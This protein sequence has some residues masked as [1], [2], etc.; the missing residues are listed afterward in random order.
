MSKRIPVVIPEPPS[1]D[2]EELQ[3]PACVNNP[4][5]KKIYHD[6]DM[7]FLLVPAPA[8]KIWAYH[9]RCE[10]TNRRTFPSLT[11]IK[12]KLNMNEG[13]VIKWRGWL[14]TNGWLKLLEPAQR[15]SDGKMSVPVFRVTRPDH[16]QPT[17]W[18]FP[19]GFSM[20]YCERESVFQ[21]PP[22]AFK[23][24]LFRLR[25]ERAE[26]HQSCM[27]QKELASKLGMHQKTVIT[28][29][30]YLK[31]NGWLTQLGRKFVA[32]TGKALPIYRCEWDGKLPAPDEEDGRL[33]NDTTKATRARL[34]KYKAGDVFLNGEQ[35][36]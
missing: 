18:S 24:W 13:T 15:Q 35:L 19:R 17:T 23:I 8:L 22:A 16:P 32:E 6:R 20:F 2:V 34:S 36:K 26:P 11:T 7:T 27:D 1:E 14:V 21:L 29:E 12:Q 33:R 3:L 5:F 9:Y 10:G 28:S 25:L 31:K 4:P 30:A